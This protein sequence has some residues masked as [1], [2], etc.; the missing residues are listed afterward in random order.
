MKTLIKIVTIFLMLF[1]VTLITPQKANAQGMPITFQV[2]YDELSPYGNWVYTPEYGYAWLPNAEPGFSPYATDGYWAYTDYGWTWVS[3]YTWGWAPFHYGRWFVDSVYGPMW[4]PGYEWAPAWVVW[5]IS[6]DCFGW[7]PLGPGVN[8]ET[9]YGRHFREPANYWRFVPQRDFGR[10]NISDYYINNDTHPNI[11]NHYKVIDNMHMD[12]MNHLR[13]GAGPD[14]REVERYTGRTFSPV[15]IRESSRPAQEMTNN[16]LLLYKPRVEKIQS[17]GQR[18]A[19]EHVANLQDLRYRAPVN[20]NMA[21]RNEIR[22]AQQKQ[23][24]THS[25]NPF[26]KP[27][28][29]RQPR[30]NAPVRN[31]AIRPQREN[32]PAMTQNFSRPME[33]QR[34]ARPAEARPMPEMSQMSR[35]EGFSAQRGYS[36]FGAS[37]IGSQEHHAYRS[38]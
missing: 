27:Q 10:R 7:A 23:M 18:P 4:V 8:L 33:I 1:G 13:Y 11:V 37:Y 17:S 26:V 12:R 5:G 25:S 20:Y 14:R 16:Q 9:A 3:F 38:R 22:T 21:N 32:P 2:F 31:E 24:V 36:H 6:G 28:A 35:P 15:A 34:S 19:P 29:V 30:E